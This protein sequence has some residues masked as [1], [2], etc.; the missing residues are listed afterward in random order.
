MI[1][2]LLLVIIA[3]MFKPIRMLAGALFMLIVLLFLHSL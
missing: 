1:V 3:L 2:L